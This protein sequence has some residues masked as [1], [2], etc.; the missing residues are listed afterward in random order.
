MNNCT[1]KK[2]TEDVHLHQL[3]EAWLGEYEQKAIVSECH[4]N[5]KYIRQSIPS[6]AKWTQINESGY[7]YVGV[8]CEITPNWKYFQ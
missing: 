6:E 8:G 2:F 3:E 1:G 7:F 5:R 4:Q